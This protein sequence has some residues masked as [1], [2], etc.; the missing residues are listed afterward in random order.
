MQVVWLL[1]PHP[2]LPPSPFTSD[3]CCGMSERTQLVFCFVWEKLVSIQ[4]SG[5]KT[6]RTV[7][8]KKPENRDT[9]SETEI[10]SVM[11]PGEYRSDMCGIMSIK[12]KHVLEL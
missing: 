4:S 9:E 6:H 5:K 8:N 11:D 7:N 2:S 1:L 10:L 3:A 12:T